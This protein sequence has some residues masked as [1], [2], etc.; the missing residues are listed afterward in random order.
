MHEN[1]LTEISHT[2]T[3]TQTLVEMLKYRKGRTTKSSIKLEI[4]SKNKGAK[5]NYFP[6][7]EVL[8]T[9]L[10]ME[11]ENVSSYSWTLGRRHCR[12]GNAYIP[13]HS[14]DWAIRELPGLQCHVAGGVEHC[15]D[16]T[17]RRCRQGRMPFLI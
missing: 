7:Q 9:P 8:R 17:P 5:F 14:L 3:H 2:H 4:R 15:S 13:Y 12:H 16:F 1:S 10:G 11:G 6:H